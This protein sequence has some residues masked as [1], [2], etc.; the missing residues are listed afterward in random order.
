MATAL[1]TFGWAALVWNGGIQ[2]I[3]SMF[4]IANQ[5]LAVLALA[6][7]TTWLVNTGKRR[8]AW[9]TVPPMVFVSITT[10]SAGA[11]MIPRLDYL[12]TGMALFVIISVCTVVVMAIANWLRPDKGRASRAA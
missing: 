11:L 2:T 6:L 7:V 12:N 4:G 3:W 5:L 1:V 9:V 10:L 8:Y